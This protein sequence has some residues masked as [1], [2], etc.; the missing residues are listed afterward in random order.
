M[1]FSFVIAIFLL[2]GSLPLSYALPINQYNPVQPIVMK[3]MSVHNLDPQ[4]PVEFMVSVPL[5]NLNLLDYYVTATSSPASRLYRHFLSL[6][7]TAALFYPTEQFN[8]AVSELKSKGFAIELTAAD[9]VI[10]ARGTASQVRTELGLTYH[11]YSNGV[12]SYYSAQGTPSIPGVFLYSSNVTALLLAHPNTLMTEKDLRKALGEP[13]GSNRTHPFDAFSVAALR[14]VYN[15][16]SYLSKGIDGKGYNI[17]ILDFEGDPY[18]T[19]QLAYFDKTNHIPDPPSFK[20]IPIGNYNP[21][22]GLVTNWAGEISGDVEIAH[23]MAP[24][25]NETL[26]IANGALPIAAVIAKVVHDHAVNVV[27]QSWFVTIEAQFENFPGLFYS[28]IYLPDLY[29][30]L[31]SVQGMTFTAAS[32]DGAAEGWSA[33]PEGNLAY[34][35]TSPYVT[36]VGGTQTYIVFGKNG[37]SFYQTAWSNEGFSPYFFNGGGSGGGVSV[38]EPKPYYQNGIPTPPTFVNGRLVPD[39]S[40]Q[41]GAPPWTSVVGIDNGTELFA[42]TSEST[43]LLSGLLALVMQATKGSLGLINPA[44]YSVA[45]SPAYS[46]SIIPITVGYNIPFVAH[47]GYNLVTGLGSINIGY[48]GNA[49]GKLKPEPKLAVQVRVLNSTQLPQREFF[50]GNKILVFA[51]ISSNGS[52]SSGGSFSATLQTVQ[53]NV[54]TAQLAYNGS[55]KIWTGSLTVPSNANGISYV[56]VSGSSGGLAGAGFTNIFTGYY[57]T[58]L[59]PFGSNPYSTAFGLSVIANATT[60]SGALAPANPLRL[61]VLSY[62]FTQNVYSPVNTTT[63]TFGSTPY[64]K[65]WIGTLSGNFPA[66]SLVLQGNGGINGFL[67]FMNGI[68]LERML[69]LPPVGLEPGAVAGGQDITIKGVVIAPINTP[70]ISSNNV[71]APEFVAIEYGST[72]NAKL[73]SQ[74]GKVVST[75]QVR[76]NGSGLGYFGQLHVPT[77]VTQGLYNILLNGAYSSETTGVNLTGVGFG[78]LLVAPAPSFPTIAISPTYLLQG[79]TIFIHADIRYSNGTEVKFGIY[80][81]QL[82]PSTT[83]NS[84]AALSRSQNIPLWFDVTSNTWLGNATL[85]SSQSLGSAQFLPPSGSFSGPFSVFVS[86]ISADGVPTTT[87]LSAESPFQ[88]QP[89]LMVSGQTLA[90]DKAQPFQK[91]NAAFQGDTFFALRS[92]L[93]HDIFWGTNTFKSSNSVVLN[94]A[95]NGTLNV[96]D[97]ILT[98]VEVQGGDI[99][100]TNSNITLINSDVNS[101]TLANSHLKTNSSSY[102]SISPAA[103]TVKITSPTGNGNYTGSVSGSATVTGSSIASVVVSLNGQTLKTFNQNGTV[104][105]TIPTASYPDGTY[106]LEVLATQTD[107]VKSTAAVQVSFQNQLHNGLSGLS[108][109]L[110]KDFNSVTTLAYVGIA[111][112]AVA[113]VIAIVAL[114]RKR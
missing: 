14:Q 49:M 82:Y 13:Y 42:G 104:N 72:V 60:F 98:L 43:P 23:A 27:S 65:G 10:V 12:A 41:G 66:E 89:Y 77:G 58:V 37:E 88:I 100:A 16:T 1:R 9:S 47:P 86:G 105:F 33:G 4:T 112:G 74:S 11:V 39:I 103:P 64:G 3:G 57:L 76:T 114:L 34:P 25:A 96:Q 73:V 22:L 68:G 2:L 55:T 78:Q 99:V 101:L 108:D 85:P 54:T 15:A 24:G 94:S 18:I 6:A 109:T 67:P 92:S 102:K 51:T 75:A 56:T 79:Q 50:A 7:D 29:Y 87:A 21:N 28:N 91:T 71:G 90:G 52:P 20:V 17:G 97:S 113:V 61:S 45:Q 70:P 5:R 19:Q 81:A 83:R 46:K 107:G 38:V 110:S 106:R 69:I 84:Y 32:G 53:G 31:G 30:K 48:F 8:Q 59:T 35:G 93:A 62:N 26:Y 95:V 63:L 111:L 80:T 36:S 40:L 44:L